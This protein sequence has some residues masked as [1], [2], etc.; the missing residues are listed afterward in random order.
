MTSKKPYLLRA[1][2]EW[3]LDNSMT[4][5]VVV[6]AEADK[7]QVPTQYIQDGRIVLNISPT[8]IRDLF[9]SN[10]SLSFNARFGGTPYEIYAP[11]HAVVAIYAKETGDGMVFPLEEENEAKTEQT[12][13]PP[14]EKKSHLKVV[15]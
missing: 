1:L 13:D 2:N 12:E 8:A 5:Y 6:D 4:P 15:K 14:P 10:E 3:I 7:V 9:I 11:M